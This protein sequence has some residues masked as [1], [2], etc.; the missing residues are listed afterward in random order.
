MSAERLTE[1]EIKCSHLELELEKLQRT[2]FE[3]DSLVQK[4]EQSIKLMRDRLDAA[5]RGDN[6]IGGAG[7]KPPHY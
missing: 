4:L 3:Q 2:V 6:A 5:S 1:L 7:E